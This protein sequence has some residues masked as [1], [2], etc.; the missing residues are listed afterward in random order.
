MNKD[1]RPLESWGSVN[2]PPCSQSKQILESLGCSFHAK[3]H[4]TERCMMNCF[5][6][7]WLRTFSSLNLLP[8]FLLMLWNHKL[9]LVTFIWLFL[10]VC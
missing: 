9:V 10:D 7:L 4:L 8:R 5:V 6:C 2:L 1:S 3:Q